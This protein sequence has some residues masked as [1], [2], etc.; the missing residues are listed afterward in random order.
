MFCTPKDGTCLWESQCSNFQIKIR[1]IVGSQSWNSDN[2]KKL[3]HPI[4]KGISK[5]FKVWFKY[6][7][8]ESRTVNSLLRGGH[9][10]CFFWSVCFLVCHLFFTPFFQ[11][12]PDDG[13]SISKSVGGTHRAEETFNFW[14]H[15]YCHLKFTRFLTIERGLLL[16]LP[17]LSGGGKSP[18]SRHKISRA[19]KMSVISPCTQFILCFFH[20]I[21]F[22]GCIVIK[23]LPY[24][25]KS[26]GSKSWWQEYA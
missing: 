20:T 8:H 7:W 1:P 26:I 11:K 17:T 25:E 16:P 6:R 4:R 22:E 12:I 13:L 19:L 18:T 21:S 14:C 23:F 2:E 3:Q 5:R 9:F 24:V 10:T 15:F